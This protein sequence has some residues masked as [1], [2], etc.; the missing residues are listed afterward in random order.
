MVDTLAALL[1][2]GPVSLAVGRTRILVAT[3]NNPPTEHESPWLASRL[4]DK[5]ISAIVVHEVLDAQEIS[6]LVGWL[7]ATT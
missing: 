6:R 2:D 4:F 7:A 5:G 3:G 1:Q